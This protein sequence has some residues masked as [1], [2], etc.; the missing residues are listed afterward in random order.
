[1]L[2]VLSVAFSDD[3]LFYDTFSDGNDNGWTKPE[4]GDWTVENGEYC[5]SLGSYPS[6]DGHYISYVGNSSWTDYSVQARIKVIDDLPGGWGVLCFR[7]QNESE[8]YILMFEPSTH[9]MH[10]DVKKT[11]NWT[12]VA[13]ATYPFEKNI[14]YTI[15]AVV[16]GDSLF[17]YADNQLLVTYKDTNFSNGGA[18]CAA[19]HSHSHFDNFCVTTNNRP[20]FFTLDTNTLA[21]WR[22]N[23][24]TGDT[25]YDISGNN[26]HGVLTPGVDWATGFSGTSIYG[27]ANGDW[28][29]I[30]NITELEQCDNFR[31][32]ALV[33][34]PSYSSSVT[35]TIFY[36]G[37]TMNFDSLVIAFTIGEGHSKVLGLETGGLYAAGISNTITAPI[38]D[39]LFG[40]WMTV[41]A[42]YLNG[43]RKLFLN[44]VLIG[45]DS[46]ASISKFPKTYV[47]NIGDDVRGVDSWYLNGYVD[48]LMISRIT[49][50]TSFF[51]DD[52]YTMTHWTFNENSGDTAYD[53]SGNGNHAKIH[54][55]S[56]CPGAFGSALEFNGN[57]TYAD[58]PNA[59]S[60]C[61]ATNALTI[62]AI[63]SPTSFSSE[64]S[65]I[66]DKPG[67]YALSFHYGHPAMLLDG[68]SWW[69]T[70]NNYNA[71]ANQ[72]QH[73][74]VQYTGSKQ[75]V[76]V[77]G[78]LVSETAASG[79]IS[80]GYQNEIRIGVGYNA[81]E[82]DHWFI[83]KIDEIRV[84]RIA[85]YASTL[86]T[87]FILLPEEG[88]EVIGATAIVW[89][90]SG[91][92]N[93]N[94]ELQISTMPSFS[95]SI[96][97]SQ[98]VP[99][100]TTVIINQLADIYDI[101]LFTHLF[102]R[103]RAKNGLQYSQWS[104][105]ASFYLISKNPMQ[106]EES[107]VGEE[108]A[109]VLA[110][111]PFNPVTTLSW[112]LLNNGPVFIGVFS[113][114][115]KMVGKIADANMKKGRYTAIW[116]ARDYNQ[117]KL[118]SGIYLVKI[119]TQQF[120]RTMKAVLLK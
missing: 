93:S 107:A 91:M 58:A 118:P 30:P 36:L 14:W 101:P 95:T 97:A 73:I 37:Q 106:T 109:F 51:H 35:N 63:V 34:I 103:V 9:A 22:F 75:Q 26:Y 70:P 23:E 87:P 19:W 38:P 74:A 1:M 2:S 117:Q 85:R 100:D 69:W 99:N 5:R 66:I 25:A 11:G 40:T 112:T 72:W 120:N 68:V 13:Q 92:N 111:N 8:Y 52:A 96:V 41:S 86:Q 79:L 71:T 50:S 57:G 83:G 94:Y 33:N 84:S 43:I 45:Q 60:L 108:D 18:G 82:Y 24:G 31:I 7:I 47:S 55:A 98:T 10:L 113:L 114:D 49:S 6:T 76:F 54:A 61:I 104:P 21:L 65:H 88:S 67:T 42:E 16:R 102:I 27:D 48:E 80:Y 29:R 64:W 59:P 32:D 62:E 4:G 115:G 28:V 90:G 46:V 39:S 105:T 78:N 89:T 110:P 116:E 20:E 119:R 81:G 56:W 44:G 53:I 17:G 3:T 12:M 77:N 15:K